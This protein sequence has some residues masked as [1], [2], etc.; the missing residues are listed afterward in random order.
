MTDFEVAILVTAGELK[1]GCKIQLTTKPI[2]DEAIRGRTFEVV[3]VT[4]LAHGGYDIS[5]WMDKEL[6]GISTGHGGPDCFER[7]VPDD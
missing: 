5:I 4:R 3:A 1:P 7:V 2:I 6:Y